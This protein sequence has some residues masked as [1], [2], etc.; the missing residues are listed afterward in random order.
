MGYNVMNEYVCMCIY[1]LS[2][3]LYSRDDRDG[4]YR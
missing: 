2:K 3:Y 4:T 1:V